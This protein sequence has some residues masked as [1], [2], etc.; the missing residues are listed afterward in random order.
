MMTLG[1]INIHVLISTRNIIVRYDNDNYV[2]IVLKEIL[3]LS[4]LIEICWLRVTES[5]K[6]KEENSRI[7]CKS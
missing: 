5:Q 7:A 6:F 4:I 3:K 2:G 1:N